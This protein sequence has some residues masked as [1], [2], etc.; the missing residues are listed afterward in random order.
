MAKPTSNPSCSSTSVSLQLE[1]LGDCS[2][3]KLLS[4]VLQ[5]G[6]HPTSIRKKLLLASFFFDSFKPNSSFCALA[7]L[8]RLKTVHRHGQRHQMAHT[9]TRKQALGM[10]I[11]LLMGIPRSIY[12]RPNFQRETA[13]GVHHAIRSRALIFRPDHKIMFLR[14]CYLGG[15]P[16]EVTPFARGRQ[17]CTDVPFKRKTAGLWGSACLVPTQAKQDRTTEPN[18]C[19][20]DHCQLNKC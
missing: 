8:K 10:V 2:D 14:K 6:Q 19:F 4:T 16:V 20:Q 15:E 9:S 11:A 12:P 13:A 3:L 7:T 1:H 5:F 18:L 17:K